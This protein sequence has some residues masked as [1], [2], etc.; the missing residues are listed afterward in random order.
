MTAKP[1][2]PRRHVVGRS[3]EGETASGVSHPHV[4]ARFQEPHRYPK[5]IPDEILDNEVD[6]RSPVNGDKGLRFK[7]VSGLADADFD[8]LVFK[9]P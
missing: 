8:E 6:H 4:A 7:P 5:G 9:R 1:G 2:S 3:T